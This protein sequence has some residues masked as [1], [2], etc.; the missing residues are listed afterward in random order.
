MAAVVESAP[1]DV[2]EN[3]FG[4]GWNFCRRPWWHQVSIQHHRPT[5]ATSPRHRSEKIATE[6]FSSS[7]TSV[8]SAARAF[9]VTRRLRF[10]PDKRLYFPYEPGKQATSAVKIK[11]VSRSHSAFK[12]QTTAPKSCFMRPP[13]GILAPGESIVA[14]VVKFIE[15]NDGPLKMKTRD[16]FK[17]VSLKVKEGVEFTPELFEEQRDFVAVEQI[18]R[19]YFLDPQQ[20][21]PEL[22]KLKKRIAEAEAAQETHKQLTEDKAPVHVFGDG[23]VLEEWVSCS[24]W[25][26]LFSRL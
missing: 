18:L 1:E 20:S 4:R 22:E 21:T 3:D 11:N 24:L 5:P 14:V 16:K 25:Q 12:F 10:D 13:S 15:S 19:V 8:V 2:N 26:L 23:N 6:P 17:I 9:L 7:S